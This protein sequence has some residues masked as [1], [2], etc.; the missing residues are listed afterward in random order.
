MGAH[1]VSGGPPPAS[2]ALIVTTNDVRTD[3]N[4]VP[5]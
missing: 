2:D 1:E 5:P 3:R 4:P